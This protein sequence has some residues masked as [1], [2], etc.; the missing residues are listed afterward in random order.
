MLRVDQDA[1]RRALEMAKAES[2]GRKEQLESKLAEEPWEDVAS[3]AA[4]CCQNRTLKLKPW[5]T[6]PCDARRDVPDDR[7]AY[8]LAERLTAAGLSIFEPDPIAALAAI[9]ARAH[10]DLP[11]AA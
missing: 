3:F 11:P 10:G 6:P 5:Q 4:Y 2:P 9:E 1:L 8:A 7:K